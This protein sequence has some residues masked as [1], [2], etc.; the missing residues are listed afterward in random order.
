M[1]A[2]DRLN[3]A[4]DALAQLLFALNRR[5]RPWRERE[6]THI[7]RLPWLPKEFEHRAL[8]ALNAPSHTRE[9]Y[10]ARA[11]MLKALFD[12]ALAELQREGFY[13]D[14]PIGEAFV[15]SHDEP[16]RAWNMAEWNRQRERRRARASR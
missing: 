12:E 4:G 13:G 7:L 10:T 9:G 6:M 1:I 11:A 2:F 16:G 3:A 5:W 15:R 8:T 14:D